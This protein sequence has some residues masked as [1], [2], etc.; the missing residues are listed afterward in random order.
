MFADTLGLAQDG[1]LQWTRHRYVRTIRGH[2][3][4]PTVD[5]AAVGAMTSWDSFVAAARGSGVLDPHLGTALIRQIEPQEQPLEHCGALVS[6]RRCADGDA[7]LQA[8]RPRWHLEN[9]G[10]PELKEGFGLEPRR[11]GRNAAAA[12]CRTTLTIL[13]CNTAQL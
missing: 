1:A 10:E 9:D 4:T 12:H 11:W 13:A 2:K 5:A 3:Q 6:T 7:A 8:F